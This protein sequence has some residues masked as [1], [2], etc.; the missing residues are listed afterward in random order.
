M[1]LAVLLILVGIAPFGAAQETETYDVTFVSTWSAQTHPEGFPSSPHY[2]RLVGA[3]HDAG[4]SLW[5]PGTIASDGVESMAET[6]GTSLL[7]AEVDALRASGSAIEPLLG[8]SL[9]ASPGEATMTVVVS[10]DRPLVSLVTMIAPS[11]DWFVGVHGL[12]L[13]DG[14]GWRDEVVVELAVYDAGTDHGPTY[15]S[16]NDDATPHLPIE[17]LTSSPFV[18]NGTARPVGTLTWIR[19][20]PADAGSA[21]PEA[22]AL[23]LYPNPTQRDARARIPAGASPHVEIDMFDVLGRRVARSAAT[24]GP[25]SGV[26]TLP[27]LDTAGTYLVT[28]RRGDRVWTQRLTVR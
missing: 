18:I 2:S 24:L 11:P 27:T 28:V 13:R 3:T 6:G 1:R 17:A 9:A 10:D 20:R 19:R 23:V 8:P 7:L 25:G 14:N 21:S 26:V 15:T 12:D 5:A 22:D 16:P 4:T